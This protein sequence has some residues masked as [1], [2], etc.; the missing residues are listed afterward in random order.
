MFCFRHFGR[1]TD[2]IYDNRHKYR[3]WLLDNGF[4]IQI[5]QMRTVC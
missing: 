3:L 2:L 1:V 4:L 5:E